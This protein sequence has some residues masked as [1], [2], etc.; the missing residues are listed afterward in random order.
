MKLFSWFHKNEEVKSNNFRMTTDTQPS[1]I[2]TTSAKK[3]SLYVKE[4]LNETNELSIK[5]YHIVS[6]ESCEVIYLDSLVSQKDQFDLNTYLAQ[7][8][9]RLTMLQL[10]NQLGAKRFYEASDII[11]EILAGNTIVFVDSLPLCFCIKTSHF[12]QDNHHQSPVDHFVREKKENI[13]QLRKHVS[14]AQ[15]VIEHMNSDKNGSLTLAY[16]KG[17]VDTQVLQEVKRRLSTLASTKALTTGM[18]EEHLEDFPFSPFPQFMKTDRLNPCISHL[19]KGRVVLLI[20]GDSQALILPMTFLAFYETHKTAINHCNKKKMLL[21]PLRLIS[22]ITSVTLPS[23]YIALVSFHFNLFPYILSSIVKEALFFVT[24][25]PFLETFIVELL[26][27]AIQEIGVLFPTPIGKIIV[28]AGGLVIGDLVI[29]TDL[30]SRIMLFV[31]ALTACASFIVP[32]KEMTMAIRLLRFPMM[33]MATLFGFA[34]IIICLCI[35]WLHLSQLTSM[36]KPYF[37]FNTSVKMTNF[38]K[39]SMRSLY[40]SRE[41]VKKVKK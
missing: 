15:L 24:Y 31:V 13:F 39:K 18:V 34:G 26:I 8:T 40:A 19:L 1:F 6:Y 9:S 14:Q 36:G 25:S 41:D 11:Q 7:I 12:K 27:D 33:I 37:S 20:E 21:P 23:F 2:V 38:F 4:A 5:H 30:I 16:R 35:Y 32:H 17:A 3:N 10:F 22:F 29:S 28:L